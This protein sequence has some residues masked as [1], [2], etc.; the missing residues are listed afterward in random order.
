MDATN[1]LDLALRVLEKLKVILELSNNYRLECYT[2]PEVR[3]IQ[4]AVN[5][6]LNQGEIP[7][8]YV[9]I[10]NVMTLFDLRIVM[11]EEF[12]KDLVPK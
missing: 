5:A 7:L 1:R 6:S 12:D 10:N 11:T 3:M 2:F 9:E 8:G 4:V